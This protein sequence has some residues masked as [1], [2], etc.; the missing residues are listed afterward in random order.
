MT[1]TFE[2]P[3]CHAALDY[4]PSSRAVTVRCD[5][6][7]STVIVPETLRTGGSSS[8]STDMPNSPMLDPMMQA[9]RLGEVVK[10]VRS[11]R[12]IEAIKLFRETF[13]GS[14]W[15]CNQSGR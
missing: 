9:T 13:H 8:F 7:N 6:C 12:K 14:A 2:C 15:Q 10:L 3:N 5:F 11:G 1:Q 4:D